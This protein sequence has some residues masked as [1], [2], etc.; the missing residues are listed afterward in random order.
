VSEET[1]EKV[2]AN[3]DTK[4]TISSLSPELEKR[5][6]EF[7]QKIAKTLCENLN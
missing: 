4:P 7:H 3:D 2:P 5:I 1:P 6:A